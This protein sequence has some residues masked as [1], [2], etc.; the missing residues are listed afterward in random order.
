[1]TEKHLS[2]PAKAGLTARYFV[3]EFDKGYFED[4]GPDLKEPLEAEIYLSLLGDAFSDFLRG[5]RERERHGA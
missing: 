2:E 4:G 1:M 3:D 5:T